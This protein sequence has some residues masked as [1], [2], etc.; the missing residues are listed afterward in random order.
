MHLTRLLA[1]IHAG[2]VLVVKQMAAGPCPGARAANTLQATMQWPEDPTFPPCFNTRV[3]DAT[4]LC[5]AYRSL[6]AWF[7]V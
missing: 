4:L 1:C 7:L 6:D 3:A 5:G 2:T